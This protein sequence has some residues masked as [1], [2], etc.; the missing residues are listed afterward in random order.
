[1]AVSFALTPQSSQHGA[2]RGSSSKLPC[3]SAQERSAPVWRSAAELGRMVGMGLLP[4]RFLLG[5]AAGIEQPFKV[6]VEIPV[7]P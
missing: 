7:Q 5:P 6:D 4:N 3:T 2:E 1:M